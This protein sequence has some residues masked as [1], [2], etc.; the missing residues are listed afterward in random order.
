MRYCINM[1]FGLLVLL[2]ISGIVV[3]GQ[4]SKLAPA[5]SAGG[6]PAATCCL[7]LTASCTVEAFDLG[8]AR[9][10]C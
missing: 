3:V 5:H 4:D 6:T 10:S 9:D 2:A 8:P 7:R 1:S